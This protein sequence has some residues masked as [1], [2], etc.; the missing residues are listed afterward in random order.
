MKNCAWRFICMGCLLSSV[1][2]VCVPVPALPAL[3]SAGAVATGV[4]VSCMLI[5][6][7][8]DWRA[9]C[10][11]R[12]RARR[13]PCRLVGGK[14]LCRAGAY[15]PLP[16]SSPD[17]AWVAQCPR[18]H[19]LAACDL[20]RQRVYLNGGGRCSCA[21]VHLA[22]GVQCRDR[23]ALLVQ[24][25]AGRVGEGNV[26]RPNVGL[27]WCGLCPARQ[28]GLWQGG[29]QG[30]QVHFSQLGVQAADRLG[31][32]G[33]QRCL[34]LRRRGRLAGSDLA[35]QGGLCVQLGLRC[36]QVAGHFGRELTL[37]GVCRLCVR[38]QLA[39][40]VRVG[41][42]RTRPCAGAEYCRRCCS[43]ADV[44]A[45]SGACACARASSV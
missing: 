38:W 32:P 42:P 3:A 33:C 11:C 37:P 22:G 40:V 21:R 43:M 34:Q 17:Q 14:A 30:G 2:P 41:G 31:G 6:L 4:A 1:L 44:Y 15:R 10:G 19:H 5:R 28:A 7:A 35:G 13:L 23:Q 20:R 8:G 18:P 24:R 25:A 12:V 39:D 26:N 16:V 27:A 9:A 45:L 36:G 29:P